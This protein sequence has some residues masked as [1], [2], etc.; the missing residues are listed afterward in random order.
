M[1]TD[2][3]GI[4]N[5]VE[6]SHQKILGSGCLSFLLMGSFWNAFY[7]RLRH[8]FDNFAFSDEKNMRQ[9]IHFISVSKTITVFLIKNRDLH[10]ELTRR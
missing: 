9:G 4:N 7:W 6:K 5:I 1:K 8:V 10:I 3:H 2:N